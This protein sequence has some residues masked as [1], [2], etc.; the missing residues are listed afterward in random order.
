MKER[1]LDVIKWGLIILIA[2]IVFYIF[3]PKYYFYCSNTVMRGNRVTG[4]LELYHDI[5]D[6]LGYG[7]EELTGDCKDPAKK[8][9]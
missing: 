2:G 7:W 8:T 6:P 4:K 1:L 9:E 5:V 3:C